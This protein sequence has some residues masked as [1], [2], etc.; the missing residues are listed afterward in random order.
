MAVHAAGESAAENSGRDGSRQGALRKVASVA[1]IERREIRILAVGL[2][3]DFV[4][5]NLGYVC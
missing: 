5:L 4:S 2:A 3:R 1:R